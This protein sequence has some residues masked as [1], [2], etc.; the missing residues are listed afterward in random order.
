MYKI[1]TILGVFFL[2]AGVTGSGIAYGQHGQH[3]GMTP[4]ATY[5]QDD[6]V[7]T[8]SPKTISIDFHMPVRLLKFVLYNAAGKWI[9]INF[10]YVPDRIGHGFEM[11]I[12]IEL[13]PSS[14][15]LVKWSVVDNGQLLTSSMFRFSFGTGAIP[16]SETIESKRIPK[17]ET[18]PST[19]NYR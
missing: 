4:R 5:P 3:R 19:G 12:P 15:Y 6:A 2:L 18:L 13:P 8:V 9:D 11:P 1:T 7:L 10:P 17:Q 16:P 14:Y